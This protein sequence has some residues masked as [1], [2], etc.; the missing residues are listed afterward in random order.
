VGERAAEDHRTLGHGDARAIDPEE[1]RE[2]ELHGSGG[3]RH[4]RCQGARWRTGSTERDRCGD[5]KY[6]NRSRHRPQ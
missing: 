1:A 5:G 6:S 4:L 3:D 2:R